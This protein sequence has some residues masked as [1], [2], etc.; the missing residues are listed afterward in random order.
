[1]QADTRQD[2][3]LDHLYAAAVGAGEWQDVVAAFTRL[4][5]GHGGLINVYDVPT[6]SVR[7]VEWHNFDQNHIAALDAYWQSREPWSRA[8]L[9]QIAT[10]P[11]MLVNGFVSRG[12][13]LV[14]QKELLA[15]EWYNEFAGASLIQDCLSTVGVSNGVKG[16]ALIANTGGRPPVTYSTEQ[17]AIAASV[18]ADIQ[19]AI[20]IHVSAADSNQILAA[21]PGYLQMKLPVLAMQERRILTCNPAAMEELERS[22]LIRRVA[23]KLFAVDASLDR[24]M[25]SISRRDAVPQ[26]SVVATGLD[27]SRFLAQAIRFNRLRG[28]LMAA[29]GGD[30]PAVMLVLTS[31]DDGV[32][33]REAALRA[34][35]CF[36]PVEHA[37]TSSLVNGQSIEDIAR[38]RKASVQTIRW[39]LRNMSAKVGEHGVKGLTRLLTLLLPY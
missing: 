24:M 38:D 29:A 27:G 18:Q 23:G 4:V 2:E 36:T 17:I 1:M 26:M 14:P 5:G 30:D 25:A 16:L 34:L 31:L 39:H 28:T 10:H 11:E 37:I 6:G 3:F 32:A 8:G 9:E 20:N 7:T 12:S 21:A 33:G 15:S 13:S 22:R 19:R 35:S